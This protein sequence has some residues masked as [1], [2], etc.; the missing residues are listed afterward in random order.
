MNKEVIIQKLLSNHQEFA[1]LVSSLDE[2]GFNFSANNKWT[3]G[4]HLEH[5]YL[6]VSPLTKALILPVFILKLLFGKTNRLSK[7]YEG[8]VKKYSDKLQNGGVASGR[9]I[10]KKVSFEQ[11]EILKRKLLKNVKILCKAVNNFTEAKLDDYILP[12]PLLGKL[13]IK[14]MLYFTIYHVEHHKKLVLQNLHMQSESAK[15]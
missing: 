4:Q 8:L 5:I 15:G 3:A 12:H 2:S 7:N 1:E 10:P 6:A 14:E 11:K 13:T 9:F